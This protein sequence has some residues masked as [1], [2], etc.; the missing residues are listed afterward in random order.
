MKS[1]FERLLDKL[2]QL[3]LPAFLEAIDELYTQDPRKIQ[4]LVDV[5]GKMTEALARLLRE[6]AT[7]ARLDTPGVVGFLDAGFE[8]GR[9]F[10]VIAFMFAIPTG[11]APSPSPTKPAEITQAS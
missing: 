10:V 11:V 2:C 6:I 5:L 8:T 4:P 3:R 7:L 1:S 9:Y